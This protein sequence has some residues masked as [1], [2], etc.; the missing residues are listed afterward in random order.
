[1]CLLLIHIKRVCR[2]FGCLVFALQVESHLLLRTLSER[3]ISIGPGKR[4]RVHFQSFALLVNLAYNVMV[5]PLRQDL[6]MGARVLGLMCSFRTLEVT[7][8]ERLLALLYAGCQLPGN[9]VVL[10]ES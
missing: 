8:Q 5:L 6:P 10:L 7:Q 2:C 3:L 1:M 9:Y 4:A